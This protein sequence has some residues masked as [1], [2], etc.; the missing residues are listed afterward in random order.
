[1]R[2]QPRISRRRPQ[3]AG[4]RIVSFLCDDSFGFG[5]NGS[6]EELVEFGANVLVLRREEFVITYVLGLDHAFTVDERH[7]GDVKM[8]VGMLH[9]LEG[10]RCRAPAYGE[11]SARIEKVEIGQSV[12]GAFVDDIAHELYA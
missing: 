7:H 2:D 8:R 9:K 4:S 1:M 3:V 5:A 11:G 6:R 12:L 10:G